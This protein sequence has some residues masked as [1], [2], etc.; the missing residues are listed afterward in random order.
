[1]SKELLEDWKKDTKFANLRF[2]ILHPDS[3]IN[4]VDHKVNQALDSL[5]YMAILL[6]DRTH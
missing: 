1:M 6:H 4:R 5:E 2:A 3:E